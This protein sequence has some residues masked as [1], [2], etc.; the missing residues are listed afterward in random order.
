MLE[1][2][3]K[4]LNRYGFSELSFYQNFVLSST[5]SLHDFVKL[6]YNLKKS[7]NIRTLFDLFFFGRIIKKELIQ[8][9]FSKNEINKL[10]NHCVLEIINNKVQALVRVFFYRKFIFISDFP[11]RYINANIIDYLTDTDQ[12]FFPYFD[13]Y[14][15]TKFIDKKYEKALDVG[16]GCGFLAIVSSDNCKEVVGVDINKKAIKYANFNMKLNNL[17]NVKFIYGDLFNPVK[18][19]KFDLIISNPPRG[20]DSVIIN[21]PVSVNGGADGLRIVRKVIY[22]C[23]NYLTK[24]GLVKILISIGGE[25][26]EILKQ[27][28]KIVLK[29]KNKNTFDRFRK[30]TAFDYAW[31]NCFNDL[32]LKGLNSHLKKIIRYAQ[33]INQINSIINTGILTI[34]K[35]KT[36]YLRINTI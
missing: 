12:V 17:K 2:F 3:K 19:Q 18:G 28:L 26:N 15:F 29:N 22:K 7:G 4:K 32:L 24:N 8:K 6:D 36:Y 34:K 16:T 14:Y 11:F 30:L 33:D 9:I 5:I 13:S 35:N 1:F 25:N 31:L 20:I 27:K 21:K 23:Q 10:T